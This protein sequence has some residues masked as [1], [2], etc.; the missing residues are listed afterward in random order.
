MLL[1]NEFWETL[2][3]CLVV[4]D[5]IDRNEFLV[6]VLVLLLVV[7]GRWDGI[8]REPVVVVVVEGAAVVDND[9]DDNLRGKDDKYLT[10]DT[11]C[12]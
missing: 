1:S 6:V 3:T 9:P 7:T 5:G 4:D 10:G 11:I 8:N 2:P 12:E